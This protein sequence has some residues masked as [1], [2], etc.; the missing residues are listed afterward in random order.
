MN[1]E[2]RAMQKSVA[3]DAQD[4]RDMCWMKDCKNIFD[5]QICTSIGLTFTSLHG[6]HA[7]T[8]GGVC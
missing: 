8:R 1:S 6:D 4:P 2:L 7:Q 5:T 3:G